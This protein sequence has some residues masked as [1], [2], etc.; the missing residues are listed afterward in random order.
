[1]ASRKTVVDPYADREAEKYEKPIPSREVIMDLLAQDDG[2]MS[3]ARIAGALSL[4]DETDLEALRRRL[5]AMERDGQVI[6]NRRD[7]YGLVQKMSLISGRVTGHADGYGFLIP[8]D[9]SEDLFLS[10]KQMRALLHGD[11][12]LARVAG[13]DR[14]GRRE[15]AIVEVLERANNL[16]VGRFILEHGVGIV[17][18]DNK[19]ITQDILISA[20]NRGAATDGQIVVAEI[21]EQPS[22]RAQP[23]GK[24]VEV[25]GDHMAPGMEIDIA[26]RA[27]EL[28]LEWPPEVTKEIAGLKREVLEEHKLNRV[29]LRNLSLVTIDGED[30]RDF[31]DAVY[32]ERQGKGWRL[33]VAIADVSH[34]VATTTALD[35]EAR[36]RGNSVY[37][38]GRVIPMLPEILSNGLCS[39]NPKVDRLCMVCDMEISASGVVQRYEFVEAV[40]CSAARLTYTEVASIVVDKDMELRRAN[41]H[42][43]PHLENLYELY[44]VFR[45]RRDK[46]GAIDF[47]TTETRIMFGR[48]RKIERIVPVV[49]NDAHRLI[50]EF[51]IAANVC[52]A[53][54]LLA[55]EIPGLYRVHSGPSEEKLAN[56][57]DFLAE[58]GLSLGGGEAPEPKD[59]AKLLASLSERPDLHLIQTVMLRSLSQA[60]YSPENIGHFGLAYEAYTHFTS[61]IRRYP[62][63]LV[64]RALRHLIRKQPVNKFVYG[65]S[66]MLAFGEHCSMTERRADD[67]TR[68]A[69]DWLKCEYMMERVGEEYDGIITSVTSFGAFILLNDIYVEGLAHITAFPM[70][71][72]HYDPARHRLVGERNHRS[73]RLSDKVRI[74]VVRVDLDRRR[75]DF[76]LV[77]EGAVVSGEAMKGKSGKAPRPD[78]AKTKRSGSP[79]SAKGGKKPLAESKPTGAGDKPAKGKSRGPRKKKRS[80]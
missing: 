63:L 14:R 36:N 57:R 79:R 43:L 5:R 22:S 67:A 26:I 53:E 58:L 50:E 78:A 7:S 40:M 76:E 11:R 37:F 28:P 75:V 29:D 1:M 45:A 49:R 65:V 44:K 33:L 77:E 39:L 73:Y 71:Y 42:L 2:P 20:E 27:H 30:A 10:A 15:G 59:Y 31:D 68:D 41:E 48:D 4:E 55:N 9:G 64:H 52:T 66:D 35:Q 3:F 60:V 62:D 17:V 6:K 24:I 18:P 56:L 34:Y 8:D 25:L 74:K 16:V 23:I 12:A 51:M 47:D 69:T 54:F 13:I 19:R 70:D 61:P 46:R 80:R 21:I 72:Y 32:C 38:P